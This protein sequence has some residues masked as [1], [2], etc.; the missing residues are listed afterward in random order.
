MADFQFTTGDILQADVEALVNPVNCIGTMGVGRA[1]DFANRFPAN[2]LAYQIICLRREAHLGEVDVFRTENYTNPKFIIN[3]PT[4]TRW[5]DNI[6]I[7]DIESGLVSLAE[8]I[9]DTCIRSI[10]IPA[11]GCG[12]GGLDWNDVR[13]LIVDALEGVYNLQVTVFEPLN[14]E[15]SKNRGI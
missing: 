14:D 5:R 13:P 2:F 1:L 4:R 3:F 9:S 10:A 11:L 7:E 12:L 6:W 8:A 15:H